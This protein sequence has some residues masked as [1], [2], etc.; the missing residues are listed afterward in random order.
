MFRSNP[1]RANLQQNKSP[2]HAPS[3]SATLFSY[4]PAIRNAQEQQIGIIAEENGFFKSLKLGVVLLP[5]VK[6]KRSPGSGKGITEKYLAISREP[7]MTLIALLLI[8]GAML[9]VVGTNGG[10]LAA[11]PIPRQRGLSI[12]TWLWKIVTFPF[13]GTIYCSV[14]AD[15]LRR[16]VPDLGRPL[17]RAVPFP[18]FSQLRYYEGLHKLDLAFLMALLLLFA[19]WFL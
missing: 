2:V 16:L 19:V 10:S 7:V 6:I 9:G 17:W 4:S 18:G 8:L 3:S 5:L 13:L 15:G 14:I 12:K 1:S 11:E